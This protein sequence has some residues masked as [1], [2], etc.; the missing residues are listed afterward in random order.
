MK[1]TVKLFAAARDLAGGEQ[2]TV[3][4]PAGA[5][6]GEL[7][8][9]LRQQCPAL[10]SLLVHAMFAVDAT[11]ATDETCVPADAEIACI[12]PVSGG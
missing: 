3:E 12:P 8:E 11:Y 4:L 2:L 1:A 6:I 7:R 9:Q 5:T 10:A